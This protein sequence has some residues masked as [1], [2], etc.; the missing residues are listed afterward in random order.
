MS[1]LTPRLNR[2]AEAQ[3]QPGQKM[4]LMLDGH[5]APR[6][7]DGS[8]KTLQ[9]IWDTVP[10][11]LPPMA[12]KD[13]EAGFSVAVASPMLSHHNISPEELLGCELWSKVH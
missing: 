8:K 7:P 3:L 12:R 4:I 5:S 2:L 13:V 6:N 1:G 11:W 9:E 10:E